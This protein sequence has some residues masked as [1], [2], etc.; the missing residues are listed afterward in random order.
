MNL[1]EI[2]ERAKYRSRDIT[3]VLVSNDVWNDHINAAYL[4]FLARG[5][6]PMELGTENLIFPSGTQ[7]L[8]L[9]KDVFRLLSVRD[10]TNAKALRFISTW[11]Q[12]TAMWPDLTDLAE[13]TH[14]RPFGTKLSVY[15]VPNSPIAVSLVYYASPARMVYPT[16]E[17]IVPDRY[18]DGIISGA[19]AKMMLDDQNLEA[20]KAFSA[21]Y[22]RYCDLA[23]KEFAHT[24]GDRFTPLPRHPGPYSRPR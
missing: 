8:D 21:E 2:R 15:P 5:D 9:P 1:G 24:T 10:V 11:R 17:P 12:A 16:D 4:E 18:V 23:K 20:W 7:T 6:F 13:P 22:D 14:Y 3:N 19:V